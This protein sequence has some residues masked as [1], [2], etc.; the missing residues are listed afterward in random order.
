MNAILKPKNKK[1]IMVVMSAFSRSID[2]KNGSS[3]EK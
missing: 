2:L 1:D 3:L